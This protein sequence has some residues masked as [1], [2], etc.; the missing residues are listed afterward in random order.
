VCS[1]PN[2]SGAQ[3]QA[4]QAAAEAR[5][6]E[7]RRQQRFQEGMDGI[8]RMFSQGEGTGVAFNDEFYNRRAQ[9]Y[10]DFANPQMQE[11]ADRTQRELEYWL[12][13]RRLT[14]SSVAGERQRD[15]DLERGRAAQGIEMTAQDLVGQARGD[16]AS[17][18]QQAV[19]ALTASNDP[20]AALSVARERVGAI[21][22]PSA[23]NPVGN[24]FG[25]TM[26][27]IGSGV[28]GYRDATSPQSS[29]GANLYGST[30]GSSK[31]VG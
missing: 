8:D 1:S 15:F 12:A 16:V 30:R 2:T 9:A 4:A 29:G 14:N 18:R 22:T 3:A 26:A 31:V 7:E 28:S 17:A 25:N 20:S 19:A 27:M 24:L 10:R 23:F 5:A 11:Q 21:N 13:R 6:A